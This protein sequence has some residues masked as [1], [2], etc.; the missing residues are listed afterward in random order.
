MSEPSTLRSSGPDHKGLGYWQFIFVQRPKAASYLFAPLSTFVLVSSS[1]RSTRSAHRTCHMFRSIGASALRAGR[2]T[3]ASSCSAPSRVAL[4]AGA[5][6]RSSP[7]TQHHRGLSTLR[8]INVA[9]KKWRVP[10]IGLVV[11]I[12]GLPVGFAV[13][14]NYFGPGS[15]YPKPIRSLMHE[16]GMAYLRTGDKQDMPKAIECYTQALAGLDEL[17]TTDPKHARDAP[18]VTGL[19]ARIAAVYNDMGDLDKAIETFTDLLHR[20]LG[21]EGIADPK[22]Q[23]RRLL[24]NQLPDQERM[25]ILRALGC[26]NMLAEAYEARGRRAKRRSVVLPHSSAAASADAQAAAQWYQWCLQL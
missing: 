18:H 24:D 20:I 16:G 15:V 10:M 21:D 2:A 1:A 19:V 14:S 5:R 8:N 26:A 9:D 13:Y 12:A 22:T 6:P 23:V 11:L 17:G 7:T 4:T 3:W 25:N